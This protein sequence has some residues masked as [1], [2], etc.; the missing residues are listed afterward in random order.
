[1]TPSI[2]VVP[3]NP[4]YPP[5]TTPSH[6]ISSRSSLSPIQLYDK[7]HNPNR[8]CLLPH[9][10][11]GS[12][13]NTTSTSTNNDST[14][15]TPETEASSM[16]EPPLFDIYL[17]DYCDAELYSLE[18]CQEHER[19][20]QETSEQGVDDDSDVILCED[21]TNSTTTT[22]TAATIA[23]AVKR[24]G[25]RK[26]VAPGR[27]VKAK[28]R[29]PAYEEV[30]LIDSDDTEEGLSND[31]LT[32]LPSD[33]GDAQE[34]QMRSFLSLFHLVSAKGTPADNWPQK[35]PS[36]SPRKSGGNRSPVKLE[37][38]KEKRRRNDRS[39]LTV[40]RCATVPLTSPMGQFLLNNTQKNNPGFSDYQQERNE[41]LERFCPAPAI[42]DNGVRPRWMTVPPP[43]MEAVTVTYKAID[44]RPMFEK[45]EGYDRRYVHQYRMPR[46]QFS[47]RSRELS[48]LALSRVLLGSCR[49][50]SV[51]LVR[52]TETDI[53]VYFLHLAIERKKRELM[54]LR[55]ADLMR[56]FVSQQRVVKRPPDEC[57]DL[58]S[59]SEDEGEDGN[60]GE[61]IRRRPGPK[62]AKRLRIGGNED[63][64]MKE[65]RS[66]GEG[67]G[68]LMGAMREVKGEFGDVANF[69][70]R[71]NHHSALQMNGEA[72]MGK[73]LSVAV[74]GF[75]GGGGGGLS[76]A[77]GS[78]QTA[79]Q[80]GVLLPPS[81]NMAIQTQHSAM[82][83][84]SSLN[85][86]GQVGVVTTTPSNL[87]QSPSSYLFLTKQQLVYQQL[88]VT[89]TVA[90][91]AHV[92]E[93]E[94][95][96]VETT[97]EEVVVEAGR[98]GT[99]NNSSLVGGGGY[100]AIRMGGGGGAMQPTAI[101]LPVT[102]EKAK[103]PSILAMQL[104]QGNKGTQCID[105]HH[106]HTTASSIG[107]QQQQ[108]TSRNIIKLGARKT[109]PAAPSTGG[110]PRRRRTSVCDSTTS[111]VAVAAAAAFP[112]PKKMPSL[113]RIAPA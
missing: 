92:V 30:D 5:Q 55:K 34:H 52:L 41:R 29:K 95:V 62:G 63:D 3:K 11:Q 111:T 25:N 36:R 65:N 96:V 60:E 59:S 64:E 108:P 106:Q 58:C 24:R 48:W 93:K 18:A 47:Q 105:A 46:R 67:G 81:D 9:R 71:R 85:I 39:V 69:Q 75:G 68:M 50:C 20:C 53:R 45:D 99:S 1:M 107:Q 4:I 78:P 104:L 51:D 10:R 82:N 57:I 38:R 84:S 72:I 49:P 56:L 76:V 112:L 109:L 87:S 70:M 31:G 22:T 83:K 14:A 97:A 73:P 35:Q 110:P 2:V 80:L 27:D 102:T 91:G 15:T 42:R 66:G 103:E 40:Q 12:G 33:N 86:G 101:T 54:E 61:G 43:T 17:C 100:G 13:S 32:T 89:S 26:K 28:K 6:H 79:A 8:I 94:E 23:S 98:V 113:V 88:E 16:V 44:Y 21:D 37:K 74:G 77:Q 90:E 19:N 7:E